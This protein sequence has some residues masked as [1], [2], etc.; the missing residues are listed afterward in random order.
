[1]KESEEHK[2]EQGSTQKKTINT[3]LAQYF[4]FLYLLRRLFTPFHPTSL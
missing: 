1:M 2:A 3:F 4:L